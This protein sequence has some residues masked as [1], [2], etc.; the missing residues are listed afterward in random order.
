LRK[1]DWPIGLI[2]YRLRDLFRYFWLRDTFKDFV[3]VS[4]TFQIRPQ[5]SVVSREQKSYV[6]ALS[7]KHT[8]L[9]MY[10]YQS[11]QEL[12]LRRLAPQSLRAWMNTRVTDH[13]LDNRSAG[14][15]SVGKKKEC[16]SEP[17][18]IGSGTRNISNTSSRKSTKASIIFCSATLLR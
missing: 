8:R 3:T 17:T 4:Q 9:A 10:T 16:C 5:L 1:H 18:P 7:Q 12:Q 13:V 14:G 2:L 15:A 6:L 11:R